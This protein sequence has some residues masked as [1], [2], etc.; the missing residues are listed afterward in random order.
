MGERGGG[1]LGGV[2]LG[3]RGLVTVSSVPGMDYFHGDPPSTLGDSFL[4]ALTIFG[5]VS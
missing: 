5:Y 1:I 4:M 2:A 3:G